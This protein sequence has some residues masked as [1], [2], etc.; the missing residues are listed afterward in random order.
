MKRFKEKWNI[1]SDFQLMIILIVFAIS[2]TLSLFISRPLLS[3]FGVNKEAMSPWTFWPLRI[4][5]SLFSYYIVLVS[6]GSIFG[7][8]KFFWGFT[9]NTF[10]RFNRR[11]TAPD[12]E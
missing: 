1:E 4:F 3:I 9:K 10:G 5:I 6:V 7:Q 8:F 2:G 11:N 12:G